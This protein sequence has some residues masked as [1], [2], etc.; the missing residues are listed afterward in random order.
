MEM[1]DYIQ[2]FLCFETNLLT[3]ILKTTSNVLQINQYLVLAK[4]YIHLNFHSAIWVFGQLEN[5]FALDLLSSLFI[6]IKMTKW[7]QALKQML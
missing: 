7:N 6:R 2:K 3:N 1:D 4:S 5:M